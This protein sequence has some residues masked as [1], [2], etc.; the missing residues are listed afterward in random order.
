MG[1][2][3]GLLPSAT[4]KNILQIQ[5]GNAGLDGTLRPIE[6]CEGTESPLFLSSSLVE[7]QGLIASLTLHETDGTAG[8]AQSWLMH[9]DDNF[10][11]QTRTNAGAFVAA[12]LI[13]HNNA[14]GATDFEFRLA[15]TAAMILNATGLNVDVLGEL[16]AD[17]GLLISRLRLT[18]AVTGSRPASPNAGECYFDTTLGIPIW[19]DGA[20][21][22]DAT[23]STV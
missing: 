19:Y 18:A 8:M 6:D 21:W 11:L 1:N 7:I 13:I 23:G 2:L 4:Y 16:T 15:N 3:E 9:F 20:N 5:N 22:I 14:S 10:Q 12:N 17:A